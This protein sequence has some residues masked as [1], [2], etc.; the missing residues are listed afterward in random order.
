MRRACWHLSPLILILLL[1]PTFSYGQAWSGT[2]APS[3]AIDWTH[4]GLPATL[5]DGE[6]TPN[7]WTPPTRTQCV[8]AAC[9]TVSGGTV[10]VT[11]INAAL[12]SAPTGTYVL[13]PAGNFAISN[14]T[15]TMYTQNGVTLRGSGPQST[16]LTLSGSSQFSLGAGY[17]AG[18]CSWT[19]GFSAGT[20]SLTMSSCSGPTLV[21]GEI[22]SLAQCDSGFSGSGCTTGSS[23]DDGGLYIC[24]YTAVCQRGGE[25]LGNLPT[26]Q[27][28][29]L[30]TSVTGSGS[31]P[32]TV[33]FT[34]G[35]YMP[36]WSSARSPI[37]N[38]QQGAHT[39]APY[40]N[41]LEDMTIYASSVTPNGA[42]S[43]NSAYASWIK[44]VR[45]LGSG[46]YETIQMNGSKSCLIANSYFF[47]D[48]AIDSGYPPPIYE[49]SDS[50]DL[51]INN[52]VASG[53]PWEGN[54]S[55]EGNVLAFNYMR[56]NFTAYVLGIFQH[57][58]ANAF[59]LYEGNQATSIQ[60]DDTH[61][62]H[63]LSTLFRN[64]L[65]G[66]ED[67]YVSSNFAGIN[68]D[69]F[70]RFTN[71]IGNSI[72]SAKLTNYQATWGNALPNFVYSF[73][74]T[75]SAHSDP[76]TL[77][78]A[79]RWGNCDTVTGTCRFDTSE[80]PTTLTGNAA[81][82]VNPVPSSSNLPCS[83]FLAGYSSTTCTPL[84]SGGTGL[85]WWKVCTN[86]ATFPTSCATTRT[87]PFPP[88]GPDV[89]GGPYVNGTAYDIPAAAAWQNLPV[90]TS[91]QKSYSITSSS[92]S[93]GTETLTVSG[94]PNTTHLLGGFQITGVAACNS[95]AGAEFL[96]TGS[97]S[98]TIK[99]AVA[100]NPGS[101]AGGTFKFPDVR[102]FDERVYQA[103]SGGDPNPP[104][105]LS[106][107]VQ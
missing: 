81:P 21:A 18:S 49:G 4:A 77:S 10:T 52:I 17:G 92:W 99:Y 93:G 11:S 24:G 19:S 69:S 35:L 20:T 8:T 68:L 65:R 87:Q 42:V 89:T 6:T 103:D 90:D 43:F 41:G 28:N 106:V 50:D 102:Q 32:Y 27:Q 1:F 58:N 47:S 15:I 46:A 13:I 100:S 3:R 83:F 7:P 98:T 82:F 23:V 96:M 74:S 107:S 5:P 75:S 91:Y 105:G 86:W 80:V 33:N 40:G 44:G 67:P 53:V 55:M 94:L 61:G 70:D 2:L 56:D 22:I 66:W 26:Q 95:P 101:C 57:N 84:L 39:I 14:A 37:V 30:V 45:F 78:T 73:D 63:D 72:G 48:I 25:G 62:T 88:V 36:N 64:Y 104:T 76:L 31:G 9:N 38:W 34:P 12:A 16:T 71:S 54:G 97:T 60:E 85:S 59:H 29:V 51:V 79:L